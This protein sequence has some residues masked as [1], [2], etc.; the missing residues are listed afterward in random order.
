MGRANFTREGYKGISQENLNN[1]QFDGKH[2]L[3]FNTLGFSLKIN[4]KKG[5]FYA[6]NK[7]MFLDFSQKI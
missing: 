6:P 3:F 2:L 4:S 7:K 5:I 1:I